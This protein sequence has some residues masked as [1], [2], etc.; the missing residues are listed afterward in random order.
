MDK[1]DALTFRLSYLAKHRTKR[2]SSTERSIRLQPGLIFS[3]S[4]LLVA[5][6]LRQHPIV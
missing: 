2:Y 6:Y 3:T 1:L 4:V 5:I